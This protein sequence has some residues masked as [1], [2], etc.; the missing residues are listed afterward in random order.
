VKKVIWGIPFPVVAIGAALLLLV[1]LHLSATGWLAILVI[2]G[3]GCAFG[4][5]MMFVRR[6]IIGP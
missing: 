1:I 5:L 4:A 3:I 6:F 2:F